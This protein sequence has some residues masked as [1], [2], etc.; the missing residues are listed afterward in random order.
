MSFYSKVSALRVECGFWFF[1]IRETLVLS[2]SVALRRKLHPLV[3]ELKGEFYIEFGVLLMTGFW[4]I[5]KALG[6]RC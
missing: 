1:S 6:P 5:E 3:F 4:S 2:L